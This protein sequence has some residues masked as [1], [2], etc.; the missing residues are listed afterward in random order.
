MTKLYLTKLTLP[1]FPNFN[2]YVFFLIPAY[3]LLYII[4]VYI[5]KIHEVEIITHHDKIKINLK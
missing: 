4:F 5:R 3:N 1:S 2:L